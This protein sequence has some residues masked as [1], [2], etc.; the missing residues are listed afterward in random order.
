MNPRNVAK[1]RCILRQLPAGKLSPVS[2]KI[3]PLRGLWSGDGKHDEETLVHVY[4]WRFNILRCRVGR[5]CMIA[6]RSS[7]DVAEHDKNHTNSRTNSYTEAQIS[8]NHR[9]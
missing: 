2:G 1:A 3:Q 5:V 6:V 9:K 7:M 4:G 8:T